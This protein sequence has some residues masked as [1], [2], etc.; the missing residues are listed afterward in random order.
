MGRLLDG[1]RAPSTLGTFLRAFTHGHVQQLDKVG[2]GVLAE[3]AGRVPGLLAG[4]GSGGI[5]FVDV[6]DTIRE[7]HGYAK[8]AAAYGYSGVRGLNVQL[9]TISTPLAAP[10]I[11]AA[12][13]RRGNTASA[14]G[15]GRILAQALTAARAAGVTGRVLCR[16]D[17]AY[18]GY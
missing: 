15:P 1:V 18:Y 5:A 16:A 9:A 6:D 12:R 8:Q 11:A 14:A 17:S 10:V 3:L 7:V 2:A 13:L 4:G